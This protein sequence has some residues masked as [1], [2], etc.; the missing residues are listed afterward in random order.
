MLNF[1]LKD[2]KNREGKKC[3]PQIQPEE[4]N[5]RKREIM[6]VRAVIS[7]GSWHMLIGAK[8]SVKYCVVAHAYNSSAGAGGSTAPGQPRWHSEMLSQK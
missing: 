7:N 1:L 6:D 2:L 8:G 5:N 3:T 4:N